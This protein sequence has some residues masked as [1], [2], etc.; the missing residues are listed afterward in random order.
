MLAEKPDGDGLQH[1]AC[2][3]QAGAEGKGGAVKDL[4]LQGLI[5]EFAER[6]EDKGPLNKS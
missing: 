1:L 4:G 6:L 2:G 3:M 5:Q